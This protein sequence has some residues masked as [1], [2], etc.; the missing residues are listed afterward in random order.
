MVLAPIAGLPL[1][2]NLDWWCTFLDVHPR[3]VGLLRSSSPAKFVRGNTAARINLS[4]MP[5]ALSL[6]NASQCIR[7]DVF[8]IAM[9]DDGIAMGAPHVVSYPHNIVCL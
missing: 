2:K 8:C 4:S 6:V 9:G 1:L 5:Q 7:M 3:K